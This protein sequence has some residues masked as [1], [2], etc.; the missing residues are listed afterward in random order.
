MKREW[1][2]AAFV[3]TVALTA[4]CS[5]TSGFDDAQGY[6]P[7]PTLPE[8]DTSL[9]PTINVVT[10]VGW[11]EGAQPTPAPGTMVTA[12]AKGLDHPRWLYVLRNGD[13][14]VAETN[15]PVRPDAGKGIKG[16][17]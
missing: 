16:F 9:I 6:G 13:V 14:L 4:A 7:N 2:A 17:F 15:A 8:P 3:V 1:L 11:A 10:A 5:N 12:F